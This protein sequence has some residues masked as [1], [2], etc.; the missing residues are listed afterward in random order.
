MLEILR[1]ANWAIKFLAC[2]DLVYVWIAFFSGRW[3]FTFNFCRFRALFMGPTSLKFSNFNFKIGSHGI[4]YTFKNYFA[5][6]FSVFNNKRYPNRH[7]LYL[8]HSH[9]LVQIFFVYFSIKTYIFYFRY[10]HFKIPY[11]ILFYTILKYQNF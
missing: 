4:I 11:I 2:K 1:Y 6:V 3:A 10:L 5:T 8:E 7:L 9:Q